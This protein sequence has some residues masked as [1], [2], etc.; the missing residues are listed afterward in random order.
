MSMHTFRA[1]WSLERVSCFPFSVCLLAWLGRRL[2]THLD[3]AA[4]FTDD[5]NLGLLKLRASSLAL[6]TR[7]AHGFSPRFRRDWETISP[8]QTA[9]AG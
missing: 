7:L 4:S 6:G 2:R 8:S 3:R 5:G 9:L 1:V